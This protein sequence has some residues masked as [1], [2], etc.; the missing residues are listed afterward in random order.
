VKRLRLRFLTL[1]EVEE[2]HSNQINLYGGFPGVRDATLLESAV[3]MPAMTYGGQFL[4]E[5]LPAMAAAYLFHIAQNHAFVDG[6]KRTAIVAALEFLKLNGIEIKA[7][8][9]SLEKLVLGV[10]R[11]EVKKA[12]VADFFRRHNQPDPEFSLRVACELLRNPYTKIQ[13]LTLEK[14]DAKNPLDETLEL[15]RNL[16]STEIQLWTLEND[17]PKKEEE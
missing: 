6:N 9:R 7:S 17:N 14:A 11:G 12:E 13:L 10:A 1:V 5:D 15:L 3:A 4:H 8:G 16:S 2:I